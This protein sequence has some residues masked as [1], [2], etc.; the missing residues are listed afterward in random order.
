MTTLVYRYGL[1]RPTVGGDLVD[2]QFRLA[3]DYQNDLVRVEKDRL[4]AVRAAI[5]TDPEVARLDATIAEYEARVEA[6]REEIRAK[7][8]RRRS[9]VDTYEE[10]AEIRDVIALLRG[11]REERRPAARAAAK[12]PSIATAIEAHGVAAAAEAKRLRGVYAGRGLYWGTYLQVEQAAAAANRAT[13]GDPRFRRWTGEGLVAVQTQKGRDRA[14]GLEVSVALGGTDTRLRVV[15][16]GRTK[17]G[18]RVA[19]ATVSLRIG[20]DGRAPIWAEWPCVLHR[21]LPA[22]ARIRWAK[23]VRRLEGPRAVW[24]LHLTLAVPDRD[25]HGTG[26]VAVDVGWRLRPDGVRVAWIRSEDGADDRE[27]LLER[28]APD[29]NGVVRGDMLT[30]LERVDGVQAVRDRKLSSILLIL[31]GRAARPRSPDRSVAEPEVVGWLRK[32]DAILPDWLRA[33]TETI[34]SWRSPA[35]LA[36]LTLA[37]REQ[38]FAGD[39]EIYPMLE[40]W[41][42]RDWHLWSWVTGAAGAAIRWRRDQYRRLAADLVSRYRTIV[43]ERLDGRCLSRS[44]PLESEEVDVQ[45]VARNRHRTAALGELRE[46]LR[47]AFVRRGGEVIEVEMR[48]T[49]SECWSCGREML[50]DASQ[51]VDLACPEHGVID[52]DRNAGASLLRRWRERWSDEATDV[53]ARKGRR[54]VRKAAAPG[55]RWRKVK[56][57]KEAKDGAMAAPL[58][59]PVNGAR[60]RRVSR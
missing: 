57:A 50:G 36:A 46:T 56:E 23:V 22:G 18:G 55:G 10:R 6:R 51:S 16:T 45:A 13:G 9:R 53:G 21:P 7:R 20:S 5:S 19:F 43:L 40:A 3:H 31:A 14:P 47:H 59:E 49:T 26:A 52:Q 42:Y 8:S 41:R 4:A 60:R 27:V 54:I 12:S 2:E 29:R 33:R 44:Q 32:H 34:R 15:P 25:E 17:R 37:W 1:R 38:R 28:A 58:A 35:R 11:L 24:S 39:E 30:A 48:G